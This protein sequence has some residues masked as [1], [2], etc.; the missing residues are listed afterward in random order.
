MARNKSRVWGFDDAER[1]LLIAVTVAIPTLRAV[2]DRAE[3]RADF[4]GLWLVKSDVEE[5]DEMYSLVQALMD[6]TRGRKKLDLLDGMLA[7]LCTSMD[8]F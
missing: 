7:T 2:I 3:R 1:E 8:G 4:D 5:L 6:G